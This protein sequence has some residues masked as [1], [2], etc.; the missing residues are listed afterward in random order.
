MEVVVGLKL[1]PR[2]LS[3]SSVPSHNC[4]NTAAIE[5]DVNDYNFGLPFALFPSCP[6]PRS[7]IIQTSF[8][9]R[10]FDDEKIHILTGIQQV[11]RNFS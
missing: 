6:L 1:L 8:D 7:A 10:I 3:L 9:E 2:C 11:T 4:S 5:G